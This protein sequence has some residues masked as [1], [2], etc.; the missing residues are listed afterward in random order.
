MFADYVQEK[1]DFA[2]RT[3]NSLQPLEYKLNKQKLERLGYSPD[4]GSISIVPKI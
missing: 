2:A 3:K 1:N 4:K